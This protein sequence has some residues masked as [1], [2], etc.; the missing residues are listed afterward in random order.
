MRLPLLA[1][2]IIATAAMAQEKPAPSSATAK[3]AAVSSIAPEDLAD[4]ASY[5]P[6]VQTLVRKAAELTAMNLTYTFGSSDPKNGGMDCSGTMFHLLESCGRSDAPRQS[7]EMCRWIM[8]ASVLYRT[9]NV[10]EPDDAAFSAL[11][12]GDLLFWTGTYETATPR[13]PPISHVMLYLGKRRS[14]GK[15]VVF[16]ASDGRSYDGQHRCGVSV[17]DFAIPKRGEKSAFYGYGPL[18]GK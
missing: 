10:E 2:A 17:F 7:D 9:E 16:G 3:P 18:P 8:R 15:P 13:H 6:G 14:D 4:F 12:P 11:K 5:P 1:L